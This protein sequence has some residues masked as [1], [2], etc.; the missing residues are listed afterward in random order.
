[1]KISRTCL[2]GAMAGLMVAGYCAAQEPALSTPVD[3]V[4]YLIGDFAYASTML[5][6]A[7]AQ[8]QF[9]NE[10][11]SLSA[12]PRFADFTLRPEFK[13]YEPMMKGACAKATI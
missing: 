10:L 9:L 12:D 2:L 4:S 7:L 5:D 11:K 3:Q 13:K 1:M 6:G 8:G